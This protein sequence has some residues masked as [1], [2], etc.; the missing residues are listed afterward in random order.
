MESTITVDGKTYRL[1]HTS[2]T[3]Q[4]IS[5]RGNGRL[6]PYNGRFGRGYKLLSPNW[7]STRYSFV[8]YYVED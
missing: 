8:T 6:E 4:Y 3:R 7:R 1:H 2:Y 5:R